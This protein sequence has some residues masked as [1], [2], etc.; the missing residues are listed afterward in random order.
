[1]TILASNVL[2]KL[3]GTQVFVL[4]FMALAV[5]GTVLIAGFSALSA[6]TTR[7]DGNSDGYTTNGI[8]D[9]Y[10]GKGS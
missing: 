2:D 6:C 5:T 10:D 1:M 3:S 4:L 7:K 8:G 9:P